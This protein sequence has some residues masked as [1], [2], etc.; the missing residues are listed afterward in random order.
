MWNSFQTDEYSGMLA[1]TEKIASC[2]G[3]TVTVYHAEP[4]TKGEHPGL[5]LRPH[6]PGWDEY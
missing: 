5:I 4:L 6:M 2:N 3:E 1:R